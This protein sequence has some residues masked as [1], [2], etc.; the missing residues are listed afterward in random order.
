MTVQDLIEQAL[1]DGVIETDEAIELQNFS[2]ADVQRF[3]SIV[4][5][6]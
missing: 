4:E 3:L 5:A 2:L 1:N 6:E